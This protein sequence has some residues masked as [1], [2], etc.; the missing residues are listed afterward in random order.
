MS[1]TGSRPSGGHQVLLMRKGLGCKSQFLASLRKYSFN[2]KRRENSILSALTWVQSICLGVGRRLN[3]LKVEVFHLRWKKK[4]KKDWCC[5]GIQTNW[6]FLRRVWF[7]SVFVSI[8]SLLGLF[9]W[10][11]ERCMIGFDGC[12][13]GC[14]RSWGLTLLFGLSFLWLSF[15]GGFGWG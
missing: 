7:R 4:K 8:P 3:L 2:R 13:G 6:G 9:L 5:W 11:C 1:K 10:A 14:W 12:T 15:G